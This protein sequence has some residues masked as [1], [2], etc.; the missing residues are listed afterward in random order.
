MAS[1]PSISSLGGKTVEELYRM[2]PAE[3]TALL[4]SVMAGKTDAE[5]SEI[6]EQLKSE[7]G[8]A[9][10]IVR[11][12][13]MQIDDIIKTNQKSGNP[14]AADQGQR[15]VGELDGMLE[16][17]DDFSSHWGA[18]GLSAQTHNQTMTGQVLNF[19]YSSLDPQ[20]FDEF[21]ID[22]TQLAG[23]S[24]IFGNTETATGETPYVVL[25]MNPGD[26]LNLVEYD[27]ATGTRKFSI[28][29]APTDEYPEGIMRYL[30]VTST[31]PEA[32][33]A[34]KLASGTAGL[35]QDML[36][37]WP[38]PALKLFYPSL[39]D[40]MSCDEHIYG[41]HQRAG[42]KAGKLVGSGALAGKLKIAPD[43]NLGNIKAG[44]QTG[45]KTADGG[46][47]RKFKAGGPG[48]AKLG[49]NLGTARARS[50]DK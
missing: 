45:A 31:S 11:A 8:D 40:E 17:I 10:E 14:T 33:P 38:R 42:G 36:E 46:K 26:E 2:E 39:T 9:F 20:P 5:K 18:A 22:A 24:G 34:I 47:K 23:A 6:R 41:S 50:K 25:N 48:T 37:T 27:Q 19:S 28:T 29:S 12:Q 7:F 1:N 32:A 49:A 13:Q 44:G 3:F 35:T 21:N 4:E 16:F 43:L 30:T 15:L